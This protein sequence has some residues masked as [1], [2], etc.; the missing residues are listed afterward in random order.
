MHYIGIGNI[1]IPRM[2]CL[3]GLSV[4]LV[5]IGATFGSCLAQPAKVSDDPDIAAF[6]PRFKPEL[7]MVK[8]DTVA[9]VVANKPAYSIPKEDVTQRLNISLDSVYERN[10]SQKFA[11][12]FRILAYSGPDKVKMNEAKQ[13]VYKLFPNADLYQ[14]WIPPDYRIEF[15]DYIDKIQAYNVLVK[16]RPVIPE[17]LIIRKTINLK[18]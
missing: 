11:D 8:I 2:M 1:K 3:I 15:G 17:A 4:V 9:S 7:P 16:A 12:G 10:K 14:E 5:F 13:K 6:R 18:K